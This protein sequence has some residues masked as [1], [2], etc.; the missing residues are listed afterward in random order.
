MSSRRKYDLLSVP[1][2][3]LEYRLQ[4]ARKLG[5]ISLPRDAS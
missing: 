3:A 4:D 5:G 2:F 1:Y